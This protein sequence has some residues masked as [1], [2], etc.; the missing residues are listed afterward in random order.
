MMRIDLPYTDDEL[1][2]TVRELLIRN[3]VRADSGVRIVAYLGSG[4]IFSLPSEIESGLFMVSKHLPAVGPATEIACCS[5][6]WRRLPDTVAP[7]RLKAGANY[8]NVRLAQVQARADGYDD[9]ILLN[10]AGRVCELPIANIFIVRD[11]VLLTPDVTSGILEGVT[12]RTVLELAGEL[13]IETIE[14]PIDRSELYVADEAFS[15]ST[16]DRVTPI[17]SID[18]L[19]VG[20]SA[21]G[22]ITLALQA[23]LEETLRGHGAHREWWECTYDQPDERPTAREGIH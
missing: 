9:A 18:R 7:P 23:R 15:S 6:T 8:H 19:P 3:R 22:P 5:S 10:S 12:R 2:E 14:R 13:G 16:P 11:G 20:H 21:V 17:T 4:R 1:L